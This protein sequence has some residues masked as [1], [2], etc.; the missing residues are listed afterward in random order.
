MVVV[1]ADR[2]DKW[3]GDGKG[4]WQGLSLPEQPPR[5][6]E[7]RLVQA[8]LLKGRF[9]LQHQVFV[10]DQEVEQ[11]GLLKRVLPCQRLGG[12]FAASGSLQMTAPAPQ[13]SAPWE[14]ALGPWGEGWRPPPSGAPG[15][16]HDGS[17]P[18][19]LV[20]LRFLLRL[21]LVL[22]SDCS[23]GGGGG[24]G[25]RGQGWGLAASCR[26]C[27]APAAGSDCEGA[28][29]GFR[30]RGGLEASC[31]G[32][33]GGRTH[34]APVA[35]SRFWH[36]PPALKAS[37]ASEVQRGGDGSPQGQQYLAG[38]EAASVSGVVVVPLRSGDGRVLALGPG[39]GRWDSPAARPSWWAPSAAGQ[40]LTAILLRSPAGWWRRPRWLHGE[41][42]SPGQTI[43][44][45][46]R[47]Y[48]AS[49]VH[50]NGSLHSKGQHPGYITYLVDNAGRATCEGAER[51]VTRAVGGL[52]SR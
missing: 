41:R 42:G 8:A 11:V 52:P 10:G 12:L 5:K 4:P 24:A 13:T 19:F 16:V 37:P 22:G 14:L 31:R 25:V 35:A 48:Y 9:L 38:G 18:S 2:A 28:G 47:R 50:T 17:S 51:E 1:I 34:M 46:V 26:D 49:R 36:K 45:Q 20:F 32:G 30:G 7:G 39:E 33:G 43:L 23:S 44:T 6:G 29:A 15:V 3:P 21:V 27:L 40:C